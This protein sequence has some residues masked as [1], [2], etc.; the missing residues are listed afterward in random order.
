MVAGL[1]AATTQST[2]QAAIPGTDARHSG[3]EKSEE[4]HQDSM[5][6][7][8]LQ[9][10]EVT[11]TRAGE[12]T[13]IAFTNLSK[14]EI[15]SNNYGLDIPSLLALTPSMVA[16]NE[17][18]IGIGGTSMRL[19][20]TDA[21]RLNVTINGVA[22]NNPDSHAMYWYDTPDLASAVGDMQI[23]RGAGTSTHGTGAFGGAISMTTSS[24]VTDFGGDVSMSYGSYNTQKQAVHLA[25]GLLGDHWMV[26]ARL[27]H[28]GSEGYVDRGATDLKSYFLQGAYYSGRTVV[29]LLT[30]GGK[31][32]TYLTYDG[33]SKADMERYGRRYHT[34]GQYTTEYG[35]YQLA[36]GTRVDYY[37][38]ETDNYLQLN[39]QLLLSHQFGERWAMNLTGFYTYGYGYYKQYKD[40]AWLMGYNNL[41]TEIETADL[42]RQKKMENHFAGLN[43]TFSYSAREFDLLFGGSYSFYNSP[44]WGTLDWVEGMIPGEHAGR[45]YDNNVEKHDANLFAKINWQFTRNV[46]LFADLQ[47]RFVNYHAWGT[48]DNYDWTTYE[49]QPIAVDKQYHF[50]N[51]HIGL[52]YT[53]SKRHQLYVSFALAQKEP[54]RADF[55]D[56]YLFSSDR[57]VQP[58]PELLYD[59]E[60]GYRYT[61][62]RLQ[63]SANLY[64]MSYRDQLIHTGMVNDSSDALNVNV[65][66]SYRCGIELSA[67]WQVTK[68][69]TLGANSTL[70][71]NK[72]RDFVDLLSES[73]TY[74]QNLGDKRISY[75]PEVLAGGFLDFHAKGFEAVLRTNYVG[76]QYFTNTEN[77]ALKLDAYCVTNLDLSYTLKSKALKSVRFG[78]TLYNLFNTTYESNGYGYSYMY[79]GER[80][81]EAFYFPQAPLHILANVT[82]KF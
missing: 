10:I 66:E 52:S 9:A 1:S 20:G 8:E 69:F 76:E 13:P 72:I 70:S 63:L 57:E 77:D 64:Y 12:Q 75:S 29:K 32:K 5:R 62:P 26:D 82:V 61:A 49:M 80:Y 60:L 16:T 43:A 79:E 39:N 48:N 45:W 19:R 6:L 53:P 27:T 42:I 47:Y 40:D 37:D 24:P 51:P 34:G 14:E 2:V 22:M 50:L 44:H 23:Q 4:P 59:Y 74:G 3:T 38:D 25:S 33:V 21:T 55:T 41:P 58:T 28:I 78:V 30:F 15:A 18:G 68:W 81:D 56:R 7:Y 65:P 71:R 35:P 36:D 31:A 73:P 17:T 67:A 54:T 46:N 11:A